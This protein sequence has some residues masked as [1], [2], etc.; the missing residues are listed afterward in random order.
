MSSFET[1]AT[2]QKEDPYESPPVPLVNS[3]EYV[4]GR[5]ENIIYNIYIQEK[6]LDSP[7]PIIASL[8]AASDLA[9]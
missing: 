9:E 2:V 6:S 7:K 1:E 5:I 3:K 8:K 4:E